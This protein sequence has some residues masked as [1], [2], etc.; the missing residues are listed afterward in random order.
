MNKVGDVATSTRAIDELMQD[1]KPA[2]SIPITPPEPVKLV[3]VD[4]FKVSEQ[5]W[6]QKSQNLLAKYKFGKGLGKFGNNRRELV[7]VFSR[8]VEA[9]IEIIKFESSENSVSTE[10]LSLHFTA[11]SS[12]MML[13]ARELEKKNVSTITCDNLLA[14][15][16]GFIES[17]L[18]E[19]INV[20]KI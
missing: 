12:T 7:L 1:I 16:H 8:L 9:L 3:E 11:I 5:Y 2:S 15:L 20:R 10:D 14:T 17:Y 4:P 13:L 18:Q 6:A 19:V